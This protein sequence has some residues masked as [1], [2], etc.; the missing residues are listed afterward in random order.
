[1][2]E[3][4]QPFGQPD[5]VRFSDEDASVRLLEGAVERLWDV[6]SDL[7]RF[8]RTRRGNYRVTIFG[9]ARLKPG[10]VAY[11]AAKKLAAELTTMG[12]DIITGGGPG[13][14]RAANEGAM[15]VD[16]TALQRSVGIRVDLP[17]EQEVNP[18]VGQ[19]YEHRT[20]FSRLHHFM[21]VSD[22]FVVTPGGIG[23]LLELSLVWQLLQ[24][25]QLYNTPLILVG[26]MWSELVDWGR[27][28][29]LREGLELASPVDFTIP[30]CVDDIEAAI[31][32][33]RDNREQ[34]LK[35]QAA[36]PA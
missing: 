21:I 17:F 2:A 14:M 10:T 11:E 33:I 28:S 9:S 20:F 15:S 32:L 13:L 3:S 6:V 35:A 8:R 34:W 31:A 27:R 25:Q 1:M 30:H 18:F 36:P 24:V 19:V 7:T 22:A 23:T 5:I 12:C 29:M 4:N 26:K 16:P